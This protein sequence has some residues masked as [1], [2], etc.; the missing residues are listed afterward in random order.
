MLPLIV[1]SGQD[2][3]SLKCGYAPL[4]YTPCPREHEHDGP[5]CHEVDLASV[6]L[7]LKTA[8][9][10]LDGMDADDLDDLYWETLEGIYGKRGYA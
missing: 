6:A 8:D 3:S 10:G 1:A 9:I 2:E 7:D 5:C 4:G